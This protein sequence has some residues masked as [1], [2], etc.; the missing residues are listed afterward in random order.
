MAKLAP[1]TIVTYILRSG[2]ARGKPRPAM[3]VDHAEQ[4]GASGTADLWVFPNPR[5]DGIDAP[6]YANAVP[7][8]AA[9]TQGTWS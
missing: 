3:I 2:P 1:G 5:C 7:N 8:S 6:F 4:E 9:R